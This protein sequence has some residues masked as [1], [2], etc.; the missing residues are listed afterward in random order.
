MGVQYTRTSGGDLGGGDYFK[1]AKELLNIVEEELTVAGRDGAEEARRVL[2]ASGTGKT[3][4]PGPWGAGGTGDR[5]ETDKMRDS[6]AYRII[7]GREVGLDVGWTDIYEEY[8]GI[9]DRGFDA[10]GFRNPSAGGD[11]VKGMGIIAHLRVYMRG[12]VD[13]AMDRAV[14]RIVDGL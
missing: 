4:G 3:W 8:F 12:T 13:E 7:K 1:M 2:D 14:G 5:V 10:T 9:Q 11:A 6:L